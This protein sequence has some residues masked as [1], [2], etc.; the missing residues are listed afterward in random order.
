M[1]GGDYPVTTASD[2]LVGT[3]W[4]RR[5]RVRIVNLCRT[6]RYLGE[7][8]YCSM[9]AEARGHRVIPTVRTIR[10]LCSKSLY[11]LDTH[12]LES[13]VR[14]I[15]DTRLNLS[16][17]QSFSVV[18][19]FG[20]TSLKELQPLSREIFEL[21][22]MPLIKVTF[23]N[24]LGWQISELKPLG[25]Q[26]L[27]ADML[28]DFNQSLERF[29]SS[30]W[31]DPQKRHRA[32]YDLAILHDPAEAMPPSDRK[33]LQ[34]FMQ[35]ATRHGLDPELITQKDFGR[36]GEFDALFIRATTAIDH[37]T[38]RFA[39]KA[40]SEGLV[41]MDDPDSI[42]RCTNKI[43][44]YELLRS[45]NI[46]TP[47]TAVVSDRGMDRLAEE[48]SY[49][50]VLK[51]PDGSFSRGIHKVDSRQ[52]LLNV[53]K[54]MFKSSELLLGQAYIYTPFDWRIGVI[55]RKPLYACK[56][57]M[58][59]NHWQIYHHGEKTIEGDHKTLQ[60]EEVPAV[61]IETALKA[62]N[63]IGDGFYGVD[64]K[65]TEQG[66]LVIEIND[67]PSIESG[68]EDEL[69]G[70]RL[71]DRVMEQ[72]LL[73]IESLKGHFSNRDGTDALHASPQNDNAGIPGS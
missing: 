39:R 41:V 37:Y 26:E 44:L 5:R 27:S 3:T 23:S 21:F 72:F 54:Q 36:L 49:P 73:R 7:G 11:T 64:L 20:Y 56:Y 67:N 17:K 15:F 1:L 12:D 10:D 30:R 66:V 42:L 25:L 22:R 61:V 2:Y 40:S 34:L 29:L 28:P 60:I 47:K 46:A 14:R 6:Q 57:F 59:P 45:N 31:R 4:Q 55:N 8:Y 38:Y 52:E 50:I 62:A 13:R 16:D 43:Y 63:L 69:L 19:M 33:A 24:R 65:E 18:I 48:I 70:S 68:V 9:L 58:S 71:Y 51:A 32:K 35:S 53:A